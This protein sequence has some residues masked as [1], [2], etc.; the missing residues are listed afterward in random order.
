[1]LSFHFLRRI[2]VSAAVAA[3]VS[4]VHSPALAQE[5]VINGT[6]FR[7]IDPGP[8]RVRDQFMLGLG[9][10]AFEPVAARVLEPGEWQLDLLF[11]VSNDFAHSGAVESTLDESS[12]RGPITLEYLQSV[13]PDDPGDGKFLV[14]AETYRG[15][16]AI[17]RGIRGHAQLELM[18]QAINFQGGFLDRPIEGFHDLFQLNQAGR[19]GV[20]R[21]QFVAYLESGDQLLFVDREPESDFGDTVLGVKVDL[22][23][24]RRPPSLELAIQGRV[25]LP[26]GDSEDFTGSDS[27][28]FGVQLLSTKYFRKSSLH[29]A[30]GALYLGPWDRLDLEQQLQLSGMLALERTIGPNSTVLLQATVSQSPFRELNV[31]DLQGVSTQITVGFKRRLGRQVLFVGLTENAA[32]FDLSPDIGVHLGVTSRF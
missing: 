5:P 13:E 30:I 32:N 3:V 8:L 28:D 10:L 2:L 24:N 1:M 26:T 27:V 22:L 7:F 9:F 12:E 31:E 25:K 11:T 29:G 21:D 16:L 6:A 4:G 19:E 23:P 17:R 15:T 18:V 20:L 14:D